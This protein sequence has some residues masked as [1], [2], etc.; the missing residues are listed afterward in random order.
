MRRTVEGLCALLLAAPSVVAQPTSLSLRADP[1]AVDEGG[2]V[3]FTAWLDQ[4]AGSDFYMVFNIQDGLGR[5]WWGTSTTLPDHSASMTSVLVKS[6]EREAT[7]T[8]RA[9]VDDSVPSPSYLVR[10]AAWTSDVHGSEHPGLSSGT[11]TLTVRDDDGGGPP[12][13]GNDDDDDDGGGDGPPPGDDD[14]DDGDGDDGP[15]TP[16]AREAHIAPFWHGSGGFAVRPSDGRSTVLEIQCGA[17]IYSSREYA[18]A[19]GLIVR[20]VRLSMCFDEDDRP[21]QGEMRF[22]GIDDG[23]WYWIN[24]RY[25]VAVSPLVRE[26]SLKPDLEPAVPAGVTAIS[27]SN[28]TLMIH[29]TTGFM[30]IIPRLVD[31]DGAGR[32]AAPYWKGG[33]GVVGRPL[34]GRTATVRLSCGGGQSRRHV[35]QAGADEVIAA[36]VPGCYDSDGDPISGDLEVDGLEDGAWYWINDGK[37]YTGEDTDRPPGSCRPNACSTAAPLV[38]RASDADALTV[39]VIPGGVVAELG[40]LGALFSQGSMRGIVVRLRK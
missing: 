23:G 15:E 38:R 6:G 18:G 35:L 22:R 30:G 33:G 7:A 39:P 19:D 20:T 27:R 26:S 25:N 31:L 1:T 28:G 5:V 40:P 32:H 37:V 34:N 21:V 36:L 9:G 12:P 14:D 4:P 11:V 13:G 3:V 17:S 2:I 29:D 10:V 8:L 24:G 16:P